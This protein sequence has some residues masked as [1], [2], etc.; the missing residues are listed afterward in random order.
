MLAEW[1]KAPDCKSG[2]KRHGGSNPSHATM[3]KVKLKF[4]VD[5]EYLM[6]NTEVIDPVRIKFIDPEKVFVMGML[7]ESGRTMMLDGA[8]FE[9]ERGQAEW[10]I[11]QKIA[12]AV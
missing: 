8:V 1:L 10:M 11:E 12:V 7:G 2:S 5:P 9:F 6:N 3:E 4:R